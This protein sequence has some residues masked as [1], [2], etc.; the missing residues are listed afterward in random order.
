MDLSRLRVFAGIFRFLHLGE[1]QP[2]RFDQMRH[3]RLRAAAE[4]AQQFV[5]QPAFGNVSR[6]DSFK[7]V[8]VADLPDAAEHF[9]ALHAIDRGLYGGVRR[10]DAFAEGLLNFPDGGRAAS[11]EGVHDLQFE[12][13]EFCQGLWSHLLQ[14][15]YVKRLRVYLRG[16]GEKTGQ[17]A[18]GPRYRRPGG[19]LANDGGLRGWD[20]QAH[21]SMIGIEIE[22]DFEIAGGDLQAFKGFAFRADRAGPVDGDGAR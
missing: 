2:A 4:Q 11:P 14:H 19:L 3:D 5:D 22:H 18:T 16:K 13:C 8:S 10:L 21:Q 9:L 12:F 7:N 17:R 6:D 1:S 15:M 20:F